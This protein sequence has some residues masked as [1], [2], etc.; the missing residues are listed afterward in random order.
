MTDE[1]KITGDGARQ[2]PARAVSRYLIYTLSI[3]E[4]ALRSS[5]GLTAGAAREA[6]SFL[7]PGAFKD[8][9][10]YEI[11]VRN[12]LKFLTDDIGG[13]RRPAVAGE[14]EEE[15]PD[16]YVARKAVGNFLDLA[17]LATLHVSPVWLLAIVSDV[18]YGSKAYVAELAK[19][20]EEKGIIDE[21]S[22]IHHVDDVLEAVRRG[23]GEAATLFDTP[24]LSADELK[25]TL[26]A[27]REAIADPDYVKLLPAA[28]IQRQWGEMRKIASEENLDLIDVSAGLT[29]HTLDKVKTITHGALTGIEVAGGLFNKRILGYYAEALREVHRKGFFETVSE[30]Y[31]PYVDAVFDNFA[32]DRGTFTEEIVTGRLGGKAWRGL[33]GMFRKKP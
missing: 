21:S 7:V 14:A 2:V 5:V 27:T 9:K 17:G 12:S 13:T 25:K 29:M 22:T 10:T 16:G 24:P 31:G 30:S 3:P 18:A 1:P 23:S 8:S 19:E 28:E 20:L 11:V 33:R 26:D 32:A 6:T 15:T 4:R